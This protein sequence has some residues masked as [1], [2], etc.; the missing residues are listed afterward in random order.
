MFKSARLALVCIALSPVILLVLSAFFSIL[1]LWVWICILIGIIDDPYTEKAG[2]QDG[3]KRG[4]VQAN[5]PFL[6]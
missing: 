6:P 2:E 5:R 3:R 4:K 1:V